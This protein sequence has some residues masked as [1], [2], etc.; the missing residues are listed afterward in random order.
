MLSGPTKHAQ[1][2][3]PACMM[4]SPLQTGEHAHVQK[5]FFCTL[6]EGAV[7]LKEFKFKA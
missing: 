4:P 5:F 7:G 2:Q 6:F 3:N 1:A